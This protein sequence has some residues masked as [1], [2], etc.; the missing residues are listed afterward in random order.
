MIP[1][2]VCNVYQFLHALVVFAFVLCIRISALFT[3]S[4]NT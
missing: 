1:W 4:L 3:K 2:A